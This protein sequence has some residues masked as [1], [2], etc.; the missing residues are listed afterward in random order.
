VISN[1]SRAARP[2]HCR[3][4]LFAPFCYLAVLL[5]LLFGL[6]GCSS[7]VVSQVASLKGVKDEDLRDW[8]KKESS[9]KRLIVLVHGFNSS[10]TMAW[11][12][13]PALLT[14]DPAFNGFNIARFGYSTAGCR[15]RND[16]RDVGE[17][18]ATFL[19]NNLPQYDSAVLVG[20]SMGGLVILNALLALESNEADAALLEKDLRGMTFGTPFRG[21]ENTDWLLTFCNNKQGEA[22]SIQSPESK[23]LSEEWSKRFNRTG[24][25]HIPIYTYRGV[26]DHFVS[27]GSACGLASEC[28]VVDGDHDSIVK[29]TKPDHFTYQELRRVALGRRAVAGSGTVIKLDRLPKVGHVD[30]IGRWHTGWIRNFFSQAQIIIDTG[31]LEGT[32]QGDYFAVVEDERKITGQGGEIL[33]IVEDKGS[34]IRV[35]EVRPKFSICELAFWVYEP[36]LDKVGHKLRKVIEGAAADKEGILD[37]DKLTQSLHHKP[38]LLEILSPIEIGQKVVKTPSEEK[39][40]WDQMHEINTRTKDETVTDDE[41]KILYNELIRRADRFLLE[42]SN[43]YFAPDTLFNKAYAQFKLKRYLD[44]IDSFELFIQRYPLHGSRKGAQEHI[45]NAKKAMKKKTG[46]KQKPKDGKNAP[47]VNK[48]APFPE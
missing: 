20:H 42:F 27:Q 36:Y 7:S 28:L 9:N 23:R 10:Q 24:K 41:K 12:D 16:I 35:V 22:L 1:I 43:G 11:G 38:E 40:G 32:K 39:A 46:V 30:P 47:E 48:E 33:G 6:G 17:H 45:E 19:R 3:V 25:A 31:A 34:L 13:F 5:V 18:F 2:E 8:V 44:S 37:L 29:P 14:G 21:V 26:N 15:E 4:R